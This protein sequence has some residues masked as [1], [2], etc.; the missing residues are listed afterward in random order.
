MEQVSYT[1]SGSA[2]GA[3]VDANEGAGVDVKEGAGV[4]VKE[5][6]GVVFGAEVNSYGGFASG[7]TVATADDAGFG[8]N[9]YGGFATDEYWSCVGR[10]AALHPEN[11][12]KQITTIMAASCFFFMSTL[13]AQFD[14]MNYI[15]S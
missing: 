3:G 10:D 13:Y 6:A 14:I 1:I 8:V 11:T 15:P 12:R 2:V 7:F 9:S 5:G 4:D